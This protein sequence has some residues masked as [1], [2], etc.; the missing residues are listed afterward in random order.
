[1]PIQGDS[2]KQLLHDLLRF[3]KK[4]HTA[5][6]YQKLTV[7]G[8]AV[9]LTVPTFATYAVIYVESSIATVA[10]RYLELGDKIPPTAADG[11][12]KFTT[13][14]FDII[15]YSNLTNFRAI[16]TGAGTHTL[17]IQYYK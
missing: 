7:A 13:D 2:S 8:T 14:V 4:D 11:L 17:H 6:G 9:A 10:V 3:T 5:L 1:M 15:G 12:G 16:Q